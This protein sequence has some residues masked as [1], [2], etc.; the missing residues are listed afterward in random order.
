VTSAAPRD[1][2]ADTRHAQLAGLIRDWATDLG[3]QQVGI[4][5][6]DLGDA[7]ARLQQWLARGWQGD[8]E[9]LSATVRGARD[10]RSWCRAHC[11]SSPS[12]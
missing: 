6:C 4:A 10:R 5:D 1:A 11:G 9:Y 8:M 2:S 12:G 7:E 3:F